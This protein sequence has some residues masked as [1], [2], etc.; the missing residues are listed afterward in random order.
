MF[1][2]LVSFLSQPAGKKLTK[3]CPVKVF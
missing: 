1:T 2:S 3:A